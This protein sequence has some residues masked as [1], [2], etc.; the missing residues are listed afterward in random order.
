MQ[1]NIIDNNGYFSIKNEGISFK[2][3]DMGRSTSYYAYNNNKEQGW[4][5]PSVK[6]LRIILKAIQEAKNTKDF[7]S[8]MD[9]ENKNAVQFITKELNTNEKNDQKISSF[10][11]K[12]YDFNYT[13]SEV[14]T[15]ET[16][17]I[18]LIKE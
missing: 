1:N 18:I 7:L 14:M 11:F 9:W 17:S 6:E 12:K 5:L 8:N 3:F 10:F 16:I 4:G 13:E 2:L 15:G